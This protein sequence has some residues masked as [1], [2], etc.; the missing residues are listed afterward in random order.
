MRH[1]RQSLLALLVLLFL[2]FNAQRLHFEEGVNP[3]DLQNFVYLLGFVI[4]VVSITIPVAKRVSTL[5][6]LLF[7]GGVYF[8]CK[9]VV[10]QQD[11]RP[12]L[13]DYHVYISITEI[14]FVALTVILARNV[15]FDLHDFET[16][17]ENITLADIGG[18]LRP[19]EEA[20]NE[21]QREVMR[22]RRYQRPLSVIIV[23]PD[24]TSLRASLQRSVQEVQQTLMMRYVVT[25]LGHTISQT[26]RRTDM[27]AEQTE[28]ER[29]VILCPEMNPIVAREL[30]KRIQFI[31]E[32]RLGVRVMCGVGSFPNEPTLNELM[33]RAEGSL[34]HEDQLSS[35]PIMEGTESRG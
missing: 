31:A 34:Q 16:A 1:L 24:P 18:R 8:L 22:S 17:V 19:L 28:R 29:F 13:G 7:W 3:I 21:M 14:A 26:L 11:V 23:E 33:H 20:E 6:A 27:L 25:S 9:L 30:I 15:A 2:F 10:F 32:K 35:I 4:V 5:I 12:L